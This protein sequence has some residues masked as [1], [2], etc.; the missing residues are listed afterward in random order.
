MIWLGI[1]LAC[2]G[3]YALK[4][5]G[6]SIPQQVLESAAVRRVSLLL[7]VGLLAALAATQTL[8]SG[9]RLVLDARVV[10]VLGAILAIRL[11]APFVV[12]IIVAAVLAVVARQLGMP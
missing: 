5:A 7:P 8:A 1:L 3:C 9:E 11:K 10:G 6:L 4:Y 12:V 2:L